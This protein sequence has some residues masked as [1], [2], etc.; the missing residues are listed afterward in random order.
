MDLELLIGLIGLLGTILGLYIAYKTYNKEYGTE[1][2][3]NKIEELKFNFSSA[4]N[5]SIKCSDT[6][7]SLILENGIENEIFLN[8]V[9]FKGYSDLLKYSQKTELDNKILEDALKNFEPFLNDDLINKT[10]DSM[11]E[12]LKKQLNELIDLDNYLNRIKFTILNKN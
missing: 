2:V 6:I 12:S 11:N 8:N 7:D 9:S 10:I 5:L 3:K 1:K 4:R